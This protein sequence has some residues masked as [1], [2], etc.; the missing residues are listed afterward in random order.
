MPHL[1]T[2]LLGKYDLSVDS[3]NGSMSFTVWQIFLHPDWSFNKTGYNSDLSVVVLSKEVELSSFIQIIHLP[4]SSEEEMDGKIVGTIVGWGKSEFDKNFD[5]KP[6]QLEVPVYKCKDE[7]KEVSLEKMFCGGYTNEGKGPC[8]GD[9][10]SGFYVLDS[11]KT[12]IISGIISSIQGNDCAGNK[13]I[14]YTNVRRYVIW[15]KEKLGESN[16]TLEEFADFECVKHQT[17]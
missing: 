13:S 4:P 12:W 11:T 2:A 6:N 17:L 8:G 16:K 9:S 3:E 1:L 5:D 7:N 15:I 10:G 14:F